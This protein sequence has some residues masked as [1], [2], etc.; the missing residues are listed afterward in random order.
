MQDTGP[1]T[2]AISKISGRLKVD[3]GKCC[4]GKK[5]CL[6]CEISKSK[7]DGKGGCGKKDGKGGLGD[8]FAIPQ[9]GLATPPV[10][11]A[12]PAYSGMTPTL[13]ASNPSFGGMA[14][15]ASPGYGTAPTSP[16]APLAAP[17]MTSK[18]H[19]SL[20]SSMG[21]LKIRGVRGASL[22]SK[23]KFSKVLGK[24]GNAK[25]PMKGLI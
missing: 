15:A 9:T 6:K 24:L 25:R 4:S 14:G 10:G 8:N 1:I 12:N 23:S 7:N 11:G 22:S 18:P 5:K 21:G 17:R 20:S 19:R 2:T 16:T 13:G 3:A